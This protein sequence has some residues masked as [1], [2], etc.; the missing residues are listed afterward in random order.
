MKQEF[1]GWLTA[2]WSRHRHFTTTIK[3]FLT[4]KKKIDGALVG[5]TAHHYT[6]LVAQMQEPTE[7]LYGWE[8]LDEFYLRGKC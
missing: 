6:F 7:L 5:V 1:L 4:K 3:D 2:A 8:K